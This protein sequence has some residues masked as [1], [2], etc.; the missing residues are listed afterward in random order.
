MNNQSKRALFDKPGSK[1]NTLIKYISEAK[2]LTEHIKIKPRDA[3]ETIKVPI[4]AKTNIKYLDHSIFLNHSID[5]ATL[6]IK[7][8]TPTEMIE[9]IWRLSLSGLHSDM[10]AGSPSPIKKTRMRQKIRVATPSKII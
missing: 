7:C 9:Y 3:N 5:E 1:N 4:I 10:S 2:R 6:I 8:I